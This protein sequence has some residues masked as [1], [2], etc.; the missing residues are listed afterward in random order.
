MIKIFSQLGKVHKLPYNVNETSKMYLNKAKNID[1][2][3]KLTNL[4]R[5]TRYWRR[6]C[7]VA[8]RY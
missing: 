3:R 7:A 2:F 4:G 6:L 8:S 5:S 1:L